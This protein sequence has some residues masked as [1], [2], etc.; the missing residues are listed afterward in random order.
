MS[1]LSNERAKGNTKIKCDDCQKYFGTKYHFE[2]H[3]L[4]SHSIVKQCKKIL[5]E[6]ENRVKFRLHRA[7]CFGNVTKLSVASRQESLLISNVPK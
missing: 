2:R 3:R 5:V 4:N 7:K 1:G 6:F